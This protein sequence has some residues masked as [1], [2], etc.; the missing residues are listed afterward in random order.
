MIIVFV[1]VIKKIVFLIILTGIIFNRKTIFFNNFTKGHTSLIEIKYMNPVRYS[2]FSFLM[3]SQ[4]YLPG[5]LRR[6]IRF[7]F[8]EIIKKI[9]FTIIIWKVIFLIILIKDNLPNNYNRDKSGCPH[10]NCLK[11]RPWFV[12][13]VIFQ[14]GA[15]PSVIILKDILGILDE[16]CSAKDYPIES[17][18]SRPTKTAPSWRMPG[19][20]LSFKIITYRGAT[21]EEWLARQIG[22]APWRMPSEGLSF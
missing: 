4:E 13:A 19:G 2:R 18:V 1:K 5:L 9:T 17:W 10:S 7:V 3:G 12:S 15:P 11:R 6:I 20:G 22:I 8:V 16:E 14:G 21:P